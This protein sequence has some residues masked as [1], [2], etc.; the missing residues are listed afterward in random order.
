MNKRL[1]GPRSQVLFLKMACKF[2]TIAGLLIYGCFS[3]NTEVRL[4]PRKVGLALLPCENIWGQVQSLE[5]NPL[6]SGL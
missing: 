1:P 5:G 3:G 2:G 6:S 4:N